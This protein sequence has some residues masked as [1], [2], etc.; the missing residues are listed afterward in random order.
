MAGFVFW[1]QEGGEFVFLVEEREFFLGGDEGRERGDLFCFFF[2][3]ERGGGREAG[4]ICF[5]G[6]G[7]FWECFFLFV[8]VLGEEVCFG[9]RV[10]VWEMVFFWEGE[11]EEGLGEGVVGEGG[12]VFWE[13]R[14]F[15][16][17]GVFFFLRKR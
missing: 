6:E 7:V 3:G 12:R 9:E 8:C 15:G 5:F 14:C 17:R 1:R 16:R 2:W 10:V 13:E 11:G 4:R